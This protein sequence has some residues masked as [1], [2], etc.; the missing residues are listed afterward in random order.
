MRNILPGFLIFLVLQS[1]SQS[2]AKIPFSGIVVSNDSIAIPGVA[3]IDTQSGK[4]L[5]HTNAKGFFQTEINADDS[6]CIYH[7]AFKRRFV[8][9]KDLGKRIILEPEVHELRQVDVIDKQEKEQ[10]HLEQTVDEIKRMAPMKKLTGYDLKSRQS[11]FID[12]N[13]SHNK[14][15]SPYFGPTIK[16]PAGKIVALVA[17]SEEK[18]QR[19]KLT[20]HYH[21]VKKPKNQNDKKK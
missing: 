2:P 14:G 3:I 7:I 21:L 11:Y 10:K 17:G 13:G 8:N 19:K 1:Y 5:A 15:F 4:I 12:E 18:R 9:G 6:V 16:S 20:S